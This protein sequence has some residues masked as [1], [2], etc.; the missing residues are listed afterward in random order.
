MEA[1][2]AS[3]RLNYNCSD[4]TFSLFI[5]CLEACIV[6]V[7]AMSIDT[8]FMYTQVAQEFFTGKDE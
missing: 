7:S 8:V 1:G 5:L 2:L 6:W 3:C 4:L